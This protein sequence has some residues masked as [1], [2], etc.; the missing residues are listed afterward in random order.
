MESGT[1]VYKISCESCGSN[2]GKQ[3]F[4]KTDGK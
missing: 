4:E 1:P 3:I 2:D